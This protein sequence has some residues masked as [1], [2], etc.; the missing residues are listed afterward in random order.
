M[1][2]IAYAT[3][4]IILNFNYENVMNKMKEQ[5][6]KLFCLESNVTSIEKNYKET[7]CFIRQRI[8]KTMKELIG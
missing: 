3:N 7:L 4:E 6:I 1:T 2:N 5:I 8:Q